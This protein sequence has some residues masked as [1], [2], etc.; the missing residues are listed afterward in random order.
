MKIILTFTDNNKIARKI[1]K[2]LISKKIAACTHIYQEAEAFYMWDDKLVNEK[3]YIIQVKTNSKN[4]DRA[5]NLI[6]EIHNYKVPAILVLDSKIM[7]EEY[8]TWFDKSIEN[9]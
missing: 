4:T 6:R 1:A 8:S 7:N 2:Q 9:K 5:C 3:E